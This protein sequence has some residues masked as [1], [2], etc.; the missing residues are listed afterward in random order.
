ME[1]K[2]IVEKALLK[3]YEFLP[4]LERG[5]DVV[6]EGKEFGDLKSDIVILADVE[7]DRIVLEFLRTTRIDLKV[8]TEEGEETIGENP[9]HLVTLDP[10][11]GSLN[12]QRRKRLPYTATMAI[13]NSVKPKFSDVQVTG[14]IDLK[15]GTLWVAE[16][17]KGCFVN[18][19]RCYTSKAKEISKGNIIIAEFYYPDN[20]KIITKAFKDFRGYL[21]NPGSAA[22]EMTL[23]ADGAVDAYICGTQKNHELGPAF[24]LIKEA[25]GT[26]IDWD[27]EDLGSRNYEFN[28]QTPVIA[29]ATP[30]LA[31]EILGKIQ[32]VL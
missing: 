23:V 17:G 5:E 29:A 15:D 6:K 18:E 11:D 32:K 2:E 28:A 19:E 9:K 30:E 4:T 1:E 31:Q 26:V 16:K 12:Y 27:G 20:R 8:I 25:G 22:Y 21:R 14:T 3:A 10:L 7:I 24:L 13:F